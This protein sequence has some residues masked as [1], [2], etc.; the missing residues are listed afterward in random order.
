VAGEESSGDAL[1][2]LLGRLSSTRRAA[3]RRP[4]RA[5]RAFDLI[6]ETS[7]GGGQ[8]LMRAL[9]DGAREFVLLAADGTPAARV[10]LR[11]ATG[12]CTQH[13]VGG[14]RITIDW[15]QATIARGPRRVT[16]SRTELRLL[17]VFVEAGARATSRAELIER[18]W[19]RSD[20]AP[21]ER[22]NALAVYVCSLRKRLGA[23]GVERAIATVRGFGYRM[24]LADESR[25]RVNRG[26]RE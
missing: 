9:V 16:L 11:L 23:V 26:R 18:V 20:L 3:V 14:V 15:L 22:E 24:L 12:A 8:R 6:L 19:P 5:E 13:D 17:A 7:A 4:F 25:R 21:A 2:E 10:R 1:V